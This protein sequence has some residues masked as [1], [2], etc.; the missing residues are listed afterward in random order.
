MT[1][2]AENDT[3][4]YVHP[5]DG[6]RAAAAVLAISAG[7]F[8]TGG[9]SLPANFENLPQTLNYTGDN[10]TSIVVTNGVTTWTKTFGYNA[11]GK[12]NAISGWVAS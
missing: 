2:T 1:I 6:K 4:T 8:D 7:G 11:A 10:M 5:D 3:F 9:A 12:V